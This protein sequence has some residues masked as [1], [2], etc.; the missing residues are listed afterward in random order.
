VKLTKIVEAIIPEDSSDSF[1][2]CITELKRDKD[3]LQ[4]VVAGNKKHA[5]ERNQLNLHCESLQAEV[6][7]ICFDADKC[8]SDLEAKVK[9][10]ETHSVEIVDEDDKN[11]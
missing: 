3:V 1:R 9:S 6:V 2:K 11:L 4:R 10:V 7:Q 5:Y 8:L